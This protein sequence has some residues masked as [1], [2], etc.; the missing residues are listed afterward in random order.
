MKWKKM[1]AAERY[2]VVEM[3][4]RG[5]IPKSEL[6]RKLGISRQTLDKAIKTAD[7]SAEEALAP[8]ERGRKGK[9]EQDVRIEHLMKQQQKLEK[10][11]QDWKTKYEIAKAFIDLQRR[12]DEGKP[13]PGQKGWKGKKKKHRKK[14]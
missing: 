3:A 9:S 14:K 7:R 5:E 6:S 13:L 8:K 10:E 4:R 2:R 12:L 11:L 1:S